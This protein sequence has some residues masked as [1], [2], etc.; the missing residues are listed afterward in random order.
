MGW[1]GVLRDLENASKRAAREEE[2]RK[3]AVVS[4]ARRQLERIWKEA[5]QLEVDE[6][7]MID[8][9]SKL[10]TRLTEDLVRSIKVT[11]R[12]GEGWSA[13]PVEIDTR[14]SSARLKLVSG[15][16]HR[17]DVRFVPDLLVSRGRVL[18][19]TFE[20]D[21]AEVRDTPSS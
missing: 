3:R 21:S 2:R 16:P 14:S 8:R 10:E 15:D 19:S 12:P 7:R 9:V 17:E 5:T 4:E 1:R 6:A 18:R 20:S 11:F 13:D